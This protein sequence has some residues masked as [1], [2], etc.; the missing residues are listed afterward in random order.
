MDKEI[1]KEGTGQTDIA[2]LLREAPR[3]TS[4]YSPLLGTCTFYT[5]SDKG[6]VICKAGKVFRTFTRYGSY[7][8]FE[9][10]E[11]MLFPSSDHRTWKDYKPETDRGLRLPLGTVLSLT[12]PDGIYYVMPHRIIRHTDGVTDEESKTVTGVL[13][14]QG[15]RSIVIALNDSPANKETKLTTQIAPDNCKGNYIK[16]YIDAVDDWNG[17]E[18]TEHL[19]AVGLSSNIHLENGQHI[20]SMGE[21]LFI[22]THRKAINEALEKIKA[23]PIADGW[24]WTSTEYSATKAWYL[25][26]YFGG[27]NYYTKATITN[28]VR[29]V[30]RLMVTACFIN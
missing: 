2:E 30:S 8:P 24:Y 4:L 21:M 20:P 15:E 9:T 18:N 13:V 28:R 16:T 22:F 5:V 26:L 12:I 25:N 11:C 7:Y 14:K 17:K 3:G 27:M 6:N 23:Q 1:M 10:G 29:P 19:K